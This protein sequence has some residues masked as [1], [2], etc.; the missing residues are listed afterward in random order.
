ML[1]GLARAAS[2]GLPGSVQARPLQQLFQQGWSASQGVT[3]W[4][5]CTESCSVSSVDVDGTSSPSTSYSHLQSH[6]RCDS[7]PA[8][9]FTMPSSCSI[10]NGPQLQLQQLRAYRIPNRV[11]QPKVPY[12]VRTGR[13]APQ[14]FPELE[15]L[16]APSGEIRWHRSVVRFPP[17][18]AVEIQ[19]G[20]PQEPGRTLVLSGKAGTI[21]LSLQAL[22]PTGLIALR[23]LRLPS[24]SSSSPAAGSK[25]PASA[26]PSGGRS[27]LVVVS[28]HKGR[29]EALGGELNKAIRGVMAGYLLGL[30]VKGVGYRMEPVEEVSEDMIRS[31]RLSPTQL[32]RRSRAPDGAA[33]KP[34]YFEAPGAAGDKQQN[35]A[36]PYNK[37]A[38]AI[39]LKVGY[40]RTAVYPLPP[41]IRA[42]FL[43]PTLLYLYGLELDE[44]KR[45][46]AEIRSVR[47]PNP[48]TG[49]G[50]QYLD[51]VVKIKARAGSK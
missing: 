33:P 13:P 29:F 47:K 16:K 22:D 3:C 6:P 35:V 48:Y 26:S 36:F 30:T 40:S 39:R 20:T 46:A 42:F 43:K 11:L 24:T 18:V 44:L 38:S 25:A 50:V 41:H 14:P 37:P 49:N 4:D 5:S 23:L 10:M 45:V 19:E 15:R 9:A 8:M 2:G 12:S 28:P 31:V 7:A 27:M 32:A 21:R 1:S 34:Y 17:E 51:E